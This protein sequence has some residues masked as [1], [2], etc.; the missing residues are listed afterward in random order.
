MI[1]SREVAFR[2]VLNRKSYSKTYYC[3]VVKIPT[4]LVK[5]LGWE[6]LKKVRITKIKDKLMLERGEGYG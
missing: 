3:Y 5:L 1:M 2:K 6:K 4:A